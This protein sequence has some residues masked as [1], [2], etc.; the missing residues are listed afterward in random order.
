MNY[1]LVLLAQAEGS[2]TAP[3]PGGGGGGGLGGLG[4]LSGMLIPFAAIFVIFY[5]LLIRPQKKQEKARREMLATLKKNDKVVTLGGIR[6]V[7]TN[8][9]DKD[10]TLKIDESGNVRVR[11]TRGAISRIVSKDDEISDDVETLA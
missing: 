5:F 8:V 6:G 4:G 2:G 3:P 10:V 7:V 1:L 11:F 9:R